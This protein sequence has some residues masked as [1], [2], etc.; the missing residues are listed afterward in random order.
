M[1]VGQ[2]FWATAFSQYANPYWQ[3]SFGWTGSQPGINYGQPRGVYDPFR[4]L[5]L[6]TKHCTDDWDAKTYTLT[7]SCY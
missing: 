3:N 1:L 2:G 4:L 5:E 7:T 6:L